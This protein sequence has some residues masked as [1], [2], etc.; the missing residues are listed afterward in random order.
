MESRAFK[1]LLIE[2]KVYAQPKQKVLTMF[3]SLL[4]TYN[5]LPQNFLNDGRNFRK[6]AV[7]KF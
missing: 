1:Q 3:G 2:T 4:P 6:P 7:Y 5:H